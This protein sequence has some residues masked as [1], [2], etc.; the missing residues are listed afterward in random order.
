MRQ[1]LIVGHEAPTTPAFSLDDLTGGAGRL[2]TLCRCVTS[3][4]LTSHACRTD[5]KIWLV[6]QDEFTVGFDGETIRHLNPDE[7]STAA[8]IK[9][10]LAER[11]DAIG[12]QPVETSPGVTLTRRGF[13]PT[14]RA[15][16]EDSTGVQLHEDGRPVVD[17]SPPDDAVFVLSDH[18]NFT[19][20]EATLIEAVADERVSLGPERLHADQAITVAHNYLDTAGYTE[21]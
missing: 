3:A 9:N 5:T 6:L 17:L 7:R 21:F 2:D 13:E 12:H 1:F 20:A 14:L 8:R 15:V 16:A 11:A 10:A 19:D 18:R 4:L